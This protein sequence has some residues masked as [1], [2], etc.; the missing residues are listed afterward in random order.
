MLQQRL[1]THHFLVL[2][3]SLKCL[4]LFPCSS[5]PDLSCLACNVISMLSLLLNLILP[6]SVRF[7]TFFLAV[8]KTEISIFKCICNGSGFEIPSWITFLFPLPFALFCLSLLINFSSKLPFI[9]L[10]S[11]V[12][13]PET[14]FFFDLFS[15]SIAVLLDISVKL[16]SSLLAN[17]LFL[18][19]STFAPLSSNSC[20]SSK[21]VFF[22]LRSAM[23]KSFLIKRLVPLSFAQFHSF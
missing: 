16:I 22:F 19:I 12:F 15:F 4:K 6:L 17:N 18:L 1:H 23:D 7:I 9:F 8:S 20:A 13:P 2:L 11:F 5:Y 3:P 14:C 21:I 10:I